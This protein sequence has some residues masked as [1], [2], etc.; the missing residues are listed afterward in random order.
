MYSEWHAAGSAGGWADSRSPEAHVNASSI[1]PAQNGARTRRSDRK[2]V[3]LALGLLI[4]TG[5][6][7]STSD[8]TGQSLDLN[9]LPGVVSLNGIPTHCEVR[10]SCTFLAKVDCGVS[11]DGPW[12][13]VDIRS[14][15]I[16][17]ACSFM[18]PPERR[19]NCPPPE[20]TCG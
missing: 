6:G 12:V 5:C 14:G 1:C 13:F 2:F 7:H 4:L 8:E 15:R 16:V 10:S 19:P 17:A 11:V 9:Q 3:W 18:L 20:W